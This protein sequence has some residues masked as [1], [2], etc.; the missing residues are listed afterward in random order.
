MVRNLKIT[1]YSIKML[2]VEKIKGAKAQ[3]ELKEGNTETEIQQDYFSKW[4]K[5]EAH[6]PLTSS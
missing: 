6:I 3:C 5:M 2:E 1:K 4:F